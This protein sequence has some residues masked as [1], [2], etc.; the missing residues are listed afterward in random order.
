MLATSPTI[1]DLTSTSRGKGSET[2]LNLSLLGKYPF[3]LNERITFFPLL[4]MEC[5]IALAQT[6]EPEGRKRYDRTDGIRESSVKGEPYPLSVWNSLFAVVGAGLDYRIFSSLFLRTELLYGFRLKTFYEV[7]ALEKAK[8]G[9]N[10]PN[11]KLSGLT[12][13]PSLSIAAG[14]RFL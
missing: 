8:K 3:P 4:G 6:R 9:V 2:M 11:P 13:G 12:S 5:Q 1:D 10:A 7:D 14:W